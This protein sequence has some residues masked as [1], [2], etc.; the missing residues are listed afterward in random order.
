MAAQQSQ[1][2]HGLTAEGGAITRDMTIAETLRRHPKTIAVFK[3]LHMEC[4]ACMGAE[5]ESIESGALMHGLE[6]EDLLKELNQA[7]AGK[8]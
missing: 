1:H 3:R 8:S 7:V 5:N 6:P 4:L 2:S